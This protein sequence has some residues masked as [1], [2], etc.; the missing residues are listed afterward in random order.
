MRQT[1][2]KRD[3]GGMVNLLNFI[4]AGQDWT[5]SKSVSKSAGIRPKM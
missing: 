1:P 3:K 4:F 2:N 5:V